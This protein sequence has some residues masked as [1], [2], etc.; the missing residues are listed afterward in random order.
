MES[1]SLQSGWYLLHTKA[2]QDN[3][4]H[5]H[6]EM[7]S[8]RVYAPKLLEKQRK[9]P[10]FPGYLFLHLGGAGDGQYHDLIH[11]PGVASN[12]IIHFGERH[13]F[14][15]PIPDDETVIAEV[16]ELEA[17]LN[18]LPVHEKPP[19][20]KVGD[21]VLLD[22]ALYEHMKMTFQ[23]YRGLNRGEVLIQYLQTRRAGHHK[24]RSQ[25]LGSKTMTVPLNQL[26][27]VAVR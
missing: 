1:L 25:P 11:M 24:T 3:K 15:T 10:L 17:R 27:P 9:I 23:G 12:P 6:L 4:A 20:F 18:A 2:Q 26:R 16:R 22:S 14:P 19:T 21:A 7:K 5:T 8:F 13:R